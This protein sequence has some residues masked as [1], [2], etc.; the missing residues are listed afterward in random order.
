MKVEVELI[1]NSSIHEPLGDKGTNPE[2]VS[3]FCQF[4][5]KREPS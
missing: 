3:T 1:N 4:N 5:L 2:L